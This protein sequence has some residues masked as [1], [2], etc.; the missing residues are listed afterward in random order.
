MKNFVANG[1]SIQL[2]AGVGGVVGGSIVK[3]GSL[4]GVVVASAAEGDQ[5]TLSLKGAYES[6]PKATGAAW[7][8]GDMLYWDATNSVLTKTGTNNTFAGYA[9]AAA[10]S[11]DALGSI[12]L[13]H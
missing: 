5:Y 7:V 12:L 10:Q 9:Y 4:I 6:L 13:S 11:G 3:Q 8:V 2:I 1:D